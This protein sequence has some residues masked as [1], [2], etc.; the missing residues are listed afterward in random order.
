MEGMA[1]MM[2][3]VRMIRIDRYYFRNWGGEDKL[4]R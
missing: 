4:V 1:S 2:Y 3:V